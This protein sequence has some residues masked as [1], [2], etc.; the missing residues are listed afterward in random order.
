MDNNIGKYATSIFKSCFVKYFMNIE[1][2]LVKIFKKPQHPTYVLYIDN[3]NKLLKNPTGGRKEYYLTNLCSN[4]KYLVIIFIRTPLTVL[5]LI[6][7]Y[8]RL[9]IRYNRSATF[10]QHKYVFELRSSN[11]ECHA[12]FT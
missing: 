12:I 2:F 1:S 4:S 7:Y 5:A 6:Y 10:L 3:I 8:L 9:Y 11:V